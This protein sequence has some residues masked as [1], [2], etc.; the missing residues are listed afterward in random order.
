MSIDEPHQ[1]TQPRKKKGVDNFK[2]FADEKREI[3]AYRI[4]LIGISIQMKP[5]ERYLLSCMFPFAWLL[6][7]HYNQNS[8]E[9]KWEKKSK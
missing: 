2:W 5:V 7:S 1:A 3:L 4:L 9:R 6:F 8:R